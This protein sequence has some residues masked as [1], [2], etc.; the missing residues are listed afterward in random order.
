[1]LFSSR[2]KDD[3][4][5]LFGRD[6]EIG[7][8]RSA[9][10]GNDPLVVI[11]G[12]R[13]T[14]KTSL[15]RSVLAEH[16]G[17]VVWL[18]MRDLE[19]MHRV[20]KGDIVGLL[21]SG[22]AEFLERNASSREEILAAL[23]TVRGIRVAGTG[24]DLGW[25]D[26]KALD[27]GGLFRRLDGWAG[28]NG[29]RIIVSIDEA[30]EL[31]KAR[32]VD[33]NAMFASVY[34]NCRNTMLVITGS[35]AGL[36]R[37][38]LALEDPDSPLFRRDVSCIDLKPLSASRSA[39]FLRLGF[40]E[41]G[42]GTAGEAGE[43]IRA[44]ASELGGVMGWLNLFGLECAR[45]GNVGAAELEAVRAAGAR[46]AKAGFRKFLSTRT[47]RGRY[48]SIMRGMR[49]GGTSWRS[50]R[51]FVR[52]DLGEAVHDKNFCDLLGVLVKA[53]FVARDGG[54]MYSIADP[55]LRHAYR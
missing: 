24:M 13:R 34:D 1:M 45:T 17:C 23:R 41:A 33:M 44:A 12:L 35:E 37:D 16:S 48:E 28:G 53:G 42:A 32:H 20:A 31:A 4:R 52:L 30:Q 5:A 54:G 36:L 43:S 19:G 50:L 6:E 29:A 14:G 47:A 9:V 8:L 40:E 55:L 15:A 46:L 25:P 21:E 3:V 39:E 22:V 7:R 26:K 27:V 10:R 49:P 18:D 11:T 51:G 38:F 2:P